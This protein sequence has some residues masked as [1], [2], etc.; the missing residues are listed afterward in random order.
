MQLGNQGYVK[1]NAVEAVSEDEMSEVSDAVPMDS[2]DEDEDLVPTP[3]LCVHEMYHL[4]IDV[5]RVR[6]T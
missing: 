3:Q 4:H 5:N 2:D 6:T 1:C